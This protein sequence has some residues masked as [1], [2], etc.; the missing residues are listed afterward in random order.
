MASFWV[1]IHDVP[2]GL[3]SKNL[4]VQ[5]GNFV[6]E[7]IEYDGSNLGKENRN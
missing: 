6:G 5:L 3:F 7:F 2:I 4:A 1:Q